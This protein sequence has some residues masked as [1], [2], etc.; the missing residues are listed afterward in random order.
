MSI[1]EYLFRK[2]L[3][4]KLKPREKEVFRELEKTHP[5]YKQE[6]FEEYKNILEG[7]ECQRKKK[8]LFK[9]WR[10]IC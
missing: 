9:Q 7:K 1:Q 6:W 2:W 10:I 8:S 5:A 3:F 4:S